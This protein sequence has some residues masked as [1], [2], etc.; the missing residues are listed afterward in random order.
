MFLVERVEKVNLF[1]GKINLMGFADNVV[2]FKLYEGVLRVPLLYGRVARFEDSL[3]SQITKIVMDTK[4]VTL[5]DWQIRYPTFAED[6]AVVCRGLSERKL[7]H[8][9]LYGTWHWSGT[10]KFTCY[11]LAVEIAKIM[12]KPHDHIQPNKTPS[13]TAPHDAQLNCIALSVMGLGRNTPFK[14]GI[15]AMLDAVLSK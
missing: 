3:V 12:G 8:C 1:C 15:T 4:Q 7:E 13:P 6:V 2:C 10:D 11:T 14:D 9:G 5:D